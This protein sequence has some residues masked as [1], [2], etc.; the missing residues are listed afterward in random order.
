MAEHDAAYFI[1]AL[2]Q[3]NWSGGYTGNQLI[4]LFNNFPVEWFVHVPPHQ[5]FTRW[6]DFWC[7]V[8]PLSDSSRGPAVHE[9]QADEFVREADQR[10]AANWGN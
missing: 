9:E 1:D 10:D 3:L 4:N 5:K 8:T 2:K 6:E 7:Y